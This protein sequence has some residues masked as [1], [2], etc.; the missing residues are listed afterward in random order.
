[1]KK[2]DANVPTLVSAR[3]I[4]VTTI[5]LTFSEDLDGTTITNADFSVSGYTLTT[6]DA[7]EYWYS[8]G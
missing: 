5:D 3:T 2:I 6:P 7:T 1:M 8:R 4:S